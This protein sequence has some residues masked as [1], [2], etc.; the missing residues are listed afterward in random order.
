MDK[1]Q[2]I[3]FQ[4]QKSQQKIYHWQKKSKKSLGIKI[5]LNLIFLI[6]KI[7]IRKV[8]LAYYPSL[9]GDYLIPISKVVSPPLTTHTTTTI[10]SIKIQLN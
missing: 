10:K 3:F 7:P 6:P 1:M 4:G 5:Y 9:S 8:H 2:N